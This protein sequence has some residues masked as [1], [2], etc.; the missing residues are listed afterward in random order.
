MP[1]QQPFIESIDKEDIWFC[2]ILLYSLITG[3]DKEIEKGEK[4]SKSL[5]K[6]IKSWIRQNRQAYK[7]GDLMIKMLATCP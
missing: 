1:P 2:G 4:G 6:N 7:I 3:K 5:I